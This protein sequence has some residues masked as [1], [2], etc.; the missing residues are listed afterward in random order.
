M[1]MGSLLFKFKK[2]SFLDANVEKNLKSFFLMMYQ[3][4]N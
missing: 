4:N 3:F 1:T 2:D